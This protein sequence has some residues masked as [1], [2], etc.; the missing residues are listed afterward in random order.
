MTSRR[1]TPKDFY[2]GRLIG[3]GSFSCV[4]LAKEVAPEGREVAIKVCEKRHI[5]KERKTE[6]IQSEKR[7]L[8]KITA[9]WEEKRPFFVRLHSTFQDTHNLYFA[10]TYAKNGDLLKF[11]EKMAERDIDCTQFYAGQ[12][13]SAVEFLHERGILHRDLK[14]ENILLNERM[15]V[16]ITDFGS[17][18]L[19][20]EGENNAAGTDGGTGEP[21]P[22]RAS[23]VGTAQY[24][25]PEILTGH[26]PSSRASDLWA[27]GCVLYQMCTG[28]PPFQSQ[29]E[30]LIFQKIQKLEYS[31]HEGFD[32]AARDLITKLLVIDPD[33]RLGAKDSTYYTSIR[34]HPFFDGLDFSTLHEATPP[35]IKE[36]VPAESLPDPVWTRNPNLEPGAENLARLQLD[37]ASDIDDELNHAIMRPISGSD[38]QSISSL[39][40]RR[41]NIANL[42]EKERR[43]YLEEQAKNN[44]FHKFVEGNLIIK[45][46]EH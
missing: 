46:G 4:Y 1:Q 14:P 27:I 35:T 41:K 29:S 43:E 18:K 33:G 15:H 11:I 21:V 2:F 5:L 32:D 38:S 22:K 26:P 45:Q 39:S 8:A 30:Y 36:F 31:F 19:L 3:E 6:Y 13:L 25:S 24:V 23:F 20:A 42:S 37:E 17:A 9:E 34:A 40:E 28:L 44:K 16:L 10:I 7:I 12:V